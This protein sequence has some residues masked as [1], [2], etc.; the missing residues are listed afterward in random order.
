MNLINALQGLRSDLL[1]DYRRHVTNRDAAIGCRVANQTTW[2]TQ[3]RR[4]IQAKKSTGSSSGASSK[5]SSSN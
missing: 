2:D 5:N 4:G 3:T 1:E